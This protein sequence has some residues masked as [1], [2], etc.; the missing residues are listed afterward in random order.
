MLPRSGRFYD[1]RAV[2]SPNHG[3]KRHQHL[4]DNTAQRAVSIATAGLMTGASSPARPWF[5]LRTPY[6]ELNER[7]QVK[8]W[9]GIVEK[10]MRE[11]LGQT[12]TYR[13]FR[14]MYEELL[15]FGTAG[16]IILSDYEKV[17]R[18]YPLTIGEY[19]IDV[20]GRGIVD[21]LY[22]KF[23]MTVGAAVQRFGYRAVS[24]HVRSMYDN[25]NLNAWIAV[26]HQIEPRRERNPLKVDNANMAWTS[27]YYEFGGEQDVV[28]R[29]SGFDDFP[30]LVPRWTTRGED[31]YGSSQGM[32]TLGD[33]KQLQQQQLRKS[34]AIDFMSLPPL[35]APV[36]SKVDMTPGAVNYVDLGQSSAQVRNLMNI[37][38]DLNAL[39][40]DI[41]DVQLRIKQAFFEDMFMMIA[42]DNRAQPATAREIAERHEEKLLMLGP[43]LESLH[44]EMLSPK[45]EI[46]FSHMVRAGLVP[47][48]PQEMQGQPL[49]IQF[50]SMLAQAQ[51]L[52][53]LG[54]V[55]RLLGTVA[56]VAPMRPDILDKV[57]MDQ[58]VDVYAD[59]LGVD[60][61]VIVADEH[62]ALVREQ[63]AEQEQA[64]AA[65]A[66]APD[67][68]ASAKDLAQME[69]A[70]G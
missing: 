29:E 68:A 15:V 5:K 40:E 31:I 33:V 39:R 14:Q 37:D 41:Q 53:G 30:A 54:S 55:D 34:Q 51:R 60:P 10:R 8:Q 20:D 13:A 47:T 70:Q 65:V 42:A 24:Q 62:V 36:G 2:N 56:M 52:V 11:V 48:P 66:A 28:L 26:L 49:V 12:N 23:D 22:R 32:L 16:D 9:L 1:T 58:I 4:L 45:I 63:R 7:P 27:N 18:N 19:A 69:Q 25:R 46:V 57:D 44:D 64:A 43:V 17:L 67:L 6:D 59:M 35:Q 38:I 3:G 21:T 61:S 50:V